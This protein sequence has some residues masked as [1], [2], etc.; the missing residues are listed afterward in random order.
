MLIESSRAFGWNEL[1]RDP[2]E[3]I[4]PSD[5]DATLRL[6]TFD[7]GERGVPAAAWAAAAAH[8]STRRGWPANPAR[9]G[10]FDGFEA[11]Q[12]RDGVHWRLWWL[13]ASGTPLNA[14]YQCPPA[15]AG[16]DDFAVESILS[17]LT[18]RRSPG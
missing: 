15:L 10:A 2:C 1:E 18:L 11:R 5:H 16:R 17:T 9:Y 12:P 14:V 13:E 7:P 3:A 6:F 8:F 4:V